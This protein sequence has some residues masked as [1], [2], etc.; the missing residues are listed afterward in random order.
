MRW[1]LGPTVYEVDSRRLEKAGAVLRPQIQTWRAPN[2]P[3]HG[4]DPHARG[5]KLA[6]DESRNDGLVIQCRIL[7]NRGHVVLVLVKLVDHARRL[8]EML[9]EGGLDAAAMVGAMRSKERAEVLD[10]MRAGTVQVVVATSLADEGLDAP[11]LSA[12]VLAAPTRNIGRTL[13]R[14]GRALRPCEG[15]PA[16]V[17]VDVVDSFGP[18]QGYARR[19]RTVYRLRGWL[20]AES[21]AR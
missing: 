21:A 1:S 6:E 8:A 2:V 3:L 4:M 12:V 19:R 9:R 11:R 20:D 10:R 17:V 14:I 7:C 15:A 13:Q 18:F 5:R 16:P